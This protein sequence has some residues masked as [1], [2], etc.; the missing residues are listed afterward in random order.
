MAASPHVKVRLSPSMLASLEFLAERDR[1]LTATI[2]ADIV[3]MY[4]RQRLRDE[5]LDAQAQD[6][7]NA[8]LR[9]AERPGA[10]VPKRY[11]SAAAYDAARAD[12]SNQ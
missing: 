10:A 12:P 2:A 7:Y 3:K 11:A 4:V 5:H 8:R 9:A 1:T 6:F